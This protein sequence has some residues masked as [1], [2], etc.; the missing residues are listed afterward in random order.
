MISMAMGSI[1]KVDETH[2]TT[3]IAS[4][5]SKAVGLKILTTNTPQLN[6]SK[7]IFQRNQIPSSGSCFI[8]S[9]FL[10]HK[11]IS[12]NKDVYMYR[13]DQSFCSEECR[14]RQ[15]YID[16]IKQLE[17]STKKM[18]QRYRQSPSISMA[19]PVFCL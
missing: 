19:S 16:D 8:K 1:F 12:F 5:E 3:K 7:P 2:E 18:V 10:C 11:H 13:G 4:M 9:C 15:I 14:S 6:H 17:I